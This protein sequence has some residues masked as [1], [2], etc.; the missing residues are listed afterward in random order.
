MDYKYIIYKKEGNV[1]SITFNMPERL[2]TFTFVGRGEDAQELYGA[3]DDAA[4][5][6]DIKVVV[7]KG[8]GRAFSVGHNLT[9]V[10]FVYGMGT[11]Q[12]DE[13]RASQRI[14]LSMDK[15]AFYDDFL[16][17]FLHP[18]ITIA[19]IH[20]YCIAG[21][22]MLATLCD[23]AIAADDAQPSHT[24]QRLGPAGNT[25]TL[26]VMIAT[27]GVKRTMDLLLTGR[28]ISGKEAAEIGLI[29][30]AVPPDKLE[31]EVDKMAKAMSL[32]P[33]DGIAMGKAQRHMAYESM[34]ITAGFAQ[35]YIMHT[36]FTDIRWEPDEYNFFKER[37]DKSAKEG[38]HGRDDRYSGLV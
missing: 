25:P 17:L 21:G 30:K 2:N 32:L 27:I 28:T 23:I 37:R 18:K 12:K 5:D 14:R 26:Q 15:T 13:R 36:M 10:G 4:K 24:E 11:G 8:S 1:A 16:S 20:G 7:L 3:L 29:T 33:R 38:F 22:L 19:Q 35:G 34:G 31:E 9:K 6:D